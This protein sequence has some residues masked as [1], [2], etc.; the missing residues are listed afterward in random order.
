MILREVVT[1]A[2][3]ARARVE[4]VVVDLGGEGG[5]LASVVRRKRWQQCYYT[6]ARTHA[7]TPYKQRE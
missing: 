1:C 5:C 7:R 4:E 3:R 2:V 6:H